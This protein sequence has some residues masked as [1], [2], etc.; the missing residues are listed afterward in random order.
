MRRSRSLV[1]P[2]ELPEL[3]DVEGC[4][5]A[6]RVAK[7]DSTRK[8]VACNHTPETNAISDRAD[9]ILSVKI[10]PIH[11]KTISMISLRRAKK[12]RWS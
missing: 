5:T 2:V 4:G 12:P 1:R 10:R 7:I 8:P 6:A 11:Y 3:N 9:R